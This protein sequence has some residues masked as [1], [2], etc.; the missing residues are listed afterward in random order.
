MKSSHL[1]NKK[2][3]L[4]AA[5]VFLM[6]FLATLLGASMM[7]V[8]IQSRL[9][10][11]Q[12][13]SLNAFSCAE[14]GI[15]AGLRELRGNLNADPNRNPNANADVFSGPDFNNVNLAQGSYTVT[16]AVGTPLPGNRPT[17]ALTSTGTS[18]IGITGRNLNRT[19]DVTVLVENPASFFTSTLEG[20]ITL[21]GGTNIN[22]DLMARNITYNAAGSPIVINGNVSYTGTETVNGNPNNIIINKT[23]NGTRT[24]RAPIVYVSLDVPRYQTL[25]TTAGGRAITEN[26][27][28]NGNINRTDLSADPNTPLAQGLVYVEGDVF[29][30]GTVTQSML[31]VATG[32]INITGDITYQLDTSVNPPR[33]PQLGLFAKKNVYIAAGAPDNLEVNAFIFADGEVF[34][35]QPANNNKGTLTFNGAIA[36]K[37][38][39]A[40]GNTINLAGAGRYQQR[41]LTYDTSLASNLSIPFMTFFANIVDWQER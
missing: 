2:G 25:A 12:Q 16:A 29:I 6:V 39:P 37:G 20:D 15:E 13:A 9:A 32:N 3:F 24:Q 34:E 14:A 40:G 33:F 41:N 31:I 23:P 27:T 36:V 4:L 17:V 21:V 18:L 1:L 35:A 5:S 11:T 38:N 8:Q 28:H 22:G 7:R 30:S 19:L 26:F 10:E